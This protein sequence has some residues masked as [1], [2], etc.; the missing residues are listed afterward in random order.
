[1]KHLLILGLI[2]ALAACAYNGRYSA[3]SAK[4]NLLLANEFLSKNKTTAGIVELSSGLQYKI[5]KS[6]TG[7]IPTDS[8]TV[9][10]YYRGYFLGEEEP[11][12]IAEDESAATIIPIPGVIDGW[13]EALTLMREGDEWIIYIPP[14]LAYGDKGAKPVVGPNMLLIYDITLLRLW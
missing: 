2:L 7:N 6:G 4:Q 10:V 12:D 1:M 11:F 3:V 13:R 14:H 9:S 8:A 5:V